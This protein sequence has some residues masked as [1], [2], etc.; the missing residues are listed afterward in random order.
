[1]GKVNFYKA[2]LAE[3]LT[4]VG[5]KTLLQFYILF[6]T[7]RRSK[8]RL[9]N[10]AT[11]MTVI[12]LLDKKTLFPRTDNLKERKRREKWINFPFPS[13]KQLQTII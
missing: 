1:M 11:G 4:L 7:R 2:F 13:A 8:K 5:E 6:E 9:S 12:R 3:I 10:K